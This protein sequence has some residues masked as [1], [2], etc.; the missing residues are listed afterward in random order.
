MHTNGDRVLRSFPKK[1]NDGFRYGF[2]VQEVDLG[3]IVRENHL[4]SFG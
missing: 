4:M 1:S 2:V 3:F